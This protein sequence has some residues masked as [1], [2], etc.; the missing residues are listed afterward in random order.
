M[1]NALVSQY[2]KDEKLKPSDIVYYKIDTIL[3]NQKKFHQTS[4]CLHV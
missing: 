1:K 4:L 2:L 3:Q